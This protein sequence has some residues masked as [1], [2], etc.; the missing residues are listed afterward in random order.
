[1]SPFPGQ[2]TRLGL[3]GTQAIIWNDRPRYLK[4]CFQLI[5]RVYGLLKVELQ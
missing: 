5:V 3:Q 4:I 2:I 1:M